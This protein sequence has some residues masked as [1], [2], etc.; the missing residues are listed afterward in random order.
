VIDPNFSATR[1]SELF[2]G[3]EAGI[4]PNF[5]VGLRY[6]GRSLQDL[7]VLRD[8]VLDG[9]TPRVATTDDTFLFGHLLGTDPLGQTVSIPVYDWKLGTT[10]YPDG[11][12]LLT[13]TA[14]E[15]DYKG[16]SLTFNKRL[17]NRWMLRGYVNVN[18]WTWNVPA[19]ETLQRPF[20]LTVG[21]GQDGEAVAPH[22]SAADAVG[23]FINSKFSYDVNGLYQIGGVMGTDMSFNLYAR[24][25]YPMPFYAAG[26][27]RNLQSGR[28]DD[29]RYPGVLVLDVGARKTMRIDRM[30]ATV[31]VDCFNVAGANTATQLQL[32]LLERGAGETLQTLSPRVARGGVRLEF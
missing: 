2:G 30:T 8:L 9:T 32:N 15:T 25:G 29:H 5:S 18:D 23:V 16:A 22:S 20:G 7:P 1:M 28:L 11:G 3:F 6:T 26:G 10:P 27:G 17:A 12:Q 14:A 13:N 19:T 31:S 4:A 21:A 24:Q